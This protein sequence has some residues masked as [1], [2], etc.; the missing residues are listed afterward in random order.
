M[1]PDLVAGRDEFT[2]LT[3]PPGHEFTHHE[4]GCLDMSP[5]QHLEQ[6]TDSLIEP[7]FRR[8]DGVILDVDGDDQAD[9]RPSMCQP[10]T[11]LLG[12]A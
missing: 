6:R 5:V 1:Q 9:V 10:L 12:L 7:W 2:E 11:I 3:V 4:E 8:W